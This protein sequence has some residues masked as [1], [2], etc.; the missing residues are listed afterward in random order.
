MFPRRSIGEVGAAAAKIVDSNVT[1]S[2][3]L[4]LA[5]VFDEANWR[6]PGFSG[7]FVE[8]GMKTE[9]LRESPPARTAR[10]LRVLHV[11]DPSWPVHT[12][13]SIRSLHLIVAQRRLRLPSHALTRPLPNLDD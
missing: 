3:A 1:I 11:L 6:L 2:R 7:D 13:Y 9:T 8:S 4:R 12:G 5:G 10:P